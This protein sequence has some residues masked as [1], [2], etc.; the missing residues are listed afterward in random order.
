MSICP[1][2]QRELEDEE[3]YICCAGV[4][5]RWRCADCH[6]VSEGFAFPYGLCPYCNGKLEL[7][8]RGAIED[9]QA[10]DAVRKAFEIEL[11]G[12]AFYQRASQD[13]RDPVLRELFAR[14]AAMEQEHM[15]ILSKRYHATLP[16]AADFQ[17][18][19]A[20]IFSGVDRKPEDP[21][22]LF[23]IAIAF[24]QRAVDF[25]SREG[26]RAPDGS[27]ERELYGELA[28]EER[29]HVALL[30]TEFRRWETGKAGIL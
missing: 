21:A 22:N 26:D 24:E 15:D 23:R 9:S 3:P 2:C 8:D 16:A 27:V 10:L 28:A 20:A 30:T 13:A 29:E 18:D 7:L 12:H 11:G 25:F 5:L 19:R 14:F 4:E 6:K 17:L 1:R